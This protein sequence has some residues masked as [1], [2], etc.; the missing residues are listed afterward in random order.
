MMEWSGRYIFSAAW[1]YTKGTDATLEAGL[2]TQTHFDV[3][4]RTAQ[5]V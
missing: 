3:M 4:R 2:D 5:C 1:D